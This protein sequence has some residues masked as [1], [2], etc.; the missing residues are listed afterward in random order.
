LRTFFFTPIVENASSAGLDSPEKLDRQNRSKQEG[1]MR[2]VGVLK[3]KICGCA[4]LSVRAPTFISIIFLSRILIVA[5]PTLFSSHHVRDMGIPNLSRHLAS[6]SEP[7]V[8]GGSHDDPSTN[9]VRSVVIDGPALVYHIHS[10]LASK[11]SSRLSQ[12]DR[13]PS[14]NEVSVAVMNYLVLLKIFN[15][16]VYV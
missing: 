7:I 2:R 3:K 1:R 4:Y 16:N 14:C 15:V 13:Q 8:F 9:S 11:G 10:T 5:S 12:I 6:L